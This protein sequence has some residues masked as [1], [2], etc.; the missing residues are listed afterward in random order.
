M[1][2]EILDKRVTIKT[3]PSVLRKID[4]VGGIDNYI[5][6][7][8]KKEIDTAFGRYLKR[9]LILERINK[10]KQ[11]EYDEAVEYHANLLAQYLKENPEILENWKPPLATE[12]FEK[13]RELYEQIE[14]E[15]QYQREF[16][17]QRL[18]QTPKKK[19]P[20]GERP[21]KLWTSFIG[22]V[23]QPPPRL[24]NAQKRRGEKLNPRID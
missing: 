2:S 4:L 15:K 24:T 18:N 1:Y 6:K 12:E 13:Q 20:Y 3:V 23:H 19:S 9:K 14:K 8:D 21:K 16:R 11:K 17:R 22:F 5:L 7:S 10:Q